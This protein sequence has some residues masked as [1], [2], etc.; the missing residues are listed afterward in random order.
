VSP[1]DLTDSDKTSYLANLWLV[2][3]ADKA[4]S[5][6]EKTLIDQVQKSIQAKRSHSGAAQKAVETGGFSLS[7]VGS[8]ADQVQNLEDMIAVALADSDLSQAE[9]DVIASFCRL[10]GIQQ[11]QLDLITSDVSKGLKAQAAMISCAKCGAQM[12]SDAR[13]CPACGAAVESA[14]R[15]ATALEFDIP[16]TGYAIAFSESTAPGFTTAVE[17]A[18]QI[19]SVQTVLKNKKTWYLVSIKSDRFMDVM[20]MAKALS[21]MRNRGIY[22]DGQQMDWDEVFGFVWC[23]TQRDQAYKPVEYCFGKD[24]NRVNPWGCKQAR[25]DWNEWSSWFSYG[26]WERT[27]IV[28]KRN[29]WIFDKERIRHDLATNLHRFRFCPYLNQRFVDAVLSAF[30]DR[31]EITDNG[32]WKYNSVYEEIPGSIKI[33]EKAGEG[34]FTY[35]REYYADGVRSRALLPLKDI[36]AK[37]SSMCEKKPDISPQVLL[38]K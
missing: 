35:T 3:R 33:I 24:E 1:V 34:E 14:A 30:P 15:V 5:D 38:T 11:E 37:A 25:M 21:G 8:F 6:Q 26:R 29:V 20:R 12:Q 27:G 36:L 22:H 23:A 32:P 2:A 13:F 9:A 28:S 16:K 7:K 10:I 31:V 4:L 19:G 17:L 18:K